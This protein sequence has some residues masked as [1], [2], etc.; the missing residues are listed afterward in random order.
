MEKGELFDFKKDVSIIAITHTL[1]SLELRIYNSLVMNAQRSAKQEGEKVRRNF[2]ISIKDL[3]SYSYFNSKHTRYLLNALDEIVKTN[4]KIDLLNDKMKGNYLSTTLLSQ[5]LMNENDPGVLNYEFSSTV[6]EMVLDPKRYAPLQLIITNQLESKYSMILYGLIQCYRKVEIPE[7]DIVKFRELFGI[8]NKYDSPAHISKEVLL[9]A[10]NEINHSP[11]IPYL[12]SFKFLPEGAKIKKSIKFQFSEK[13]IAIGDNTFFEKDIILP[14]HIY[15][16]IPSAYRGLYEIIEMIHRFIELNGED[17][18]IS[19]MV[20][21]NLHDPKKNYIAYMTKAL[22]NDYAAGDRAKNADFERIRKE[23][24]E[25]EKAINTRL[26]K[27]A[28]ENFLKGELRRK[29]LEAYFND[30]PDEKKEGIKETAIIRLESMKFQEE[31][32]II[33]SGK[34]PDSDLVSALWDKEF[35]NA[36]ENIIKGEYIAD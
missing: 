21:T 18:V 13:N 4:V 14:S 7:M 34:M 11:N 12:I 22:E 26:E 27:E 6:A 24:D 23:K 1:T 35:F 20:Y 28:E 2:S 25:R 8:V 5:V 16:L 36:I 10:I 31:A 19:N 3:V 29:T 9:P 15:E 30:L 32:D 33:R 17:F